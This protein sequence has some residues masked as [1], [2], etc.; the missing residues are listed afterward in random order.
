MSV[1]PRP[2]TLRANAL[3][4]LAT[5]SFGRPKRDRT[6]FNRSAGWETGSVLIIALLVLML[7]ALLGVSAGT[8]ASIEIRVAG[9]ERVYR[10][11][12]YRAEG[13][14]MAGAQLLQ[15]NQNIVALRESAFPHMSYAQLPDPDPFSDA[16]W[17][18][19][20]SAAAIDDRSR[21]TMVH[22]ERLARG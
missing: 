5:P 20:L 2:R 16:N 3:C 13:A 21:Y 22:T 11:N 1:K 18:P 7:L 4:R 9:N 14:A 17:V 19:P 10:Q 8:T 15:N 12:L 6:R